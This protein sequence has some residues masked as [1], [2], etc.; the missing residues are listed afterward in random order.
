[1]TVNKRMK[2]IEWEIDLDWMELLR[3]ILQGIGDWMSIL[4]GVCSPQLAPRV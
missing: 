3:I 4:N 2:R 1:M